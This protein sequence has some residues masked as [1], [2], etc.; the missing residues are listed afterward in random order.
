MSFR[1]L[2][3][4]HLGGKSQPSDSNRRRIY[5]EWWRKLRSSE[6]ERPRNIVSTL[7]A[8]KK[9]P[10]G[11]VRKSGNSHRKISVEMAPLYRS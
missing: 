8:M 9:L 7:K 1:S 4:T 3:A 2:A 6:K 5:G 10:M 11:P